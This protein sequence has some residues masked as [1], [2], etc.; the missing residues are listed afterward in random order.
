MT[1]IKRLFWPVIL[2]LMILISVAAVM[3][4]MAIAP[5]DGPG[6]SSDGRFR[7]VALRSTDGYV[8][9]ASYWAGQ[10]PEAPAVLLLHGVDGSRAAMV[11]QAHWLNDMGYAVLAIDFRGHG[12]SDQIN[13]SFGLYESRDARAAYEWL[14]A[15][16]NG[17]PIGVLG[18]SMGGA[19][20]LVGEHG[21]LPA[22]CMVLQAVYPDIR[23]AVYNRLAAGKAW[24]VA[25]ALE[26]F[27]SYQ[28]KLRYG[29]WPS[30]ISPVTAL[31]RYKGSV[32]VIGG[33][34]DAYTPPD[35]TR[36]LANAV[37][38]E[39]SL[40]IIKGRDHDKISG[41]NSQRYRERVLNFFDGC[42]GP[43]LVPDLP[44]ELLTPPSVPAQSQQPESATP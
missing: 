29:V 19:A 34:N 23:S 43:A 24:P 6:P 10:K 25:W 4:S 37:P 12:Q 36:S 5:H 14:E 27:L 38:G 28:S 35:E 3:G 42:L 7:N 17:A 40:W 31:A 2:G 39:K 41:E 33:E 22:R 8:V 13:R 9:A 30:R 26:P 15:K 44:P 1:L 11:K 16:Q 18:V 20:A 32:F 21:P